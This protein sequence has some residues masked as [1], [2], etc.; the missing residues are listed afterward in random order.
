MKAALIL[1]AFVISEAA[2]AQEVTSC[3]LLSED[4]FARVWQCAPTPLPA[5][6]PKSSEANNPSDGAK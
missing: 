3:K 2:C 5:P 1:L 4:K 6:A